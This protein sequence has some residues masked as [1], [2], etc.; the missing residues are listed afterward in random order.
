MKEKEKRSAIALNKFTRNG[1]NRNLM[2]TDVFREG[3]MSSPSCPLTLNDQG[4]SKVFLINR[5]NRIRVS[6]H[7]TNHRAIYRLHPD[8]PRKIRRGAVTQTLHADDTNIWSLVS[9][10]QLI[11]ALESER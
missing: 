5:V 3:S 7:K 10:Q 2:T 6:P 1:K 4:Q 11:P 9:T 8:A